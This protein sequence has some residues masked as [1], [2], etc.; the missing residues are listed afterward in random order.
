M[1]LVMYSAIIVQLWL[2]R[3]SQHRFS[4]RDIMPS[5]ITEWER[6]RPQVWF[7]LDG[8]REN[9]MSQTCSQ[10]QHYPMRWKEHS[11]KTYSKIRLRRSL[12]RRFP[13]WYLL[14]C[15]EFEPGRQGQAR[16]L[17]FTVWDGK[18]DQ[19][20]CGGYSSP[21]CEWRRDGFLP[22]ISRRTYYF[23]LLCCTYVYRACSAGRRA[24][25]GWWVSLVQMK[26]LSNHYIMG[27]ATAHADCN[28]TGWDWWYK[29]NRSRCRLTIECR[30]LIQSHQ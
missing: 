26:L 19:F 4:I 22:G 1:V 13:Q 16:G 28:D 3:A 17:S 27:K 14:A 24:V 10:R 12:E 23:V 20:H 5:V 29:P 9:I 11:F 15:A 6:H 18:I 2:T 30:M 8:L 25:V 7:E 21:D